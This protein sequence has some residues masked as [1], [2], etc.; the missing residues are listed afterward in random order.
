MVEDLEERLLKVEIA[1]VE[2]KACQNAV[3]AQVSSI[4]EAIAAIKA[5][6]QIA[7]LLVKWVVMPM[8]VILGGLVGIKV[9]FPS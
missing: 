9:L 1:V 4:N 5:N 7:E 8:I 3:G 2:L 6:Y